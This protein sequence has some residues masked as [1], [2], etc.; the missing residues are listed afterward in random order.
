MAALSKLAAAL[1]TSFTKSAM[2]DGEVYAVDIL[3]IGLQVKPNIN[4]KAVKR[5]D[6]GMLILVSRSM[7]LKGPRLSRGL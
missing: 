3:T 7:V 2:S 5:M 1:F 4:F 6:M